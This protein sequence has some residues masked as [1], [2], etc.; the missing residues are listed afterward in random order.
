MITPTAIPFRFFLLGATGRTG[1]PFLVQALACGHF[2]TVFIRNVSESIN[3]HLQAVGT[4]SGPVL[5]T[6]CVCHGVRLP[7]FC[8]RMEFG[9]AQARKAVWKKGQLESHR[10]FSV[11]LAQRI[12]KRF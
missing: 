4:G 3:A 6:C 12:Q 8:S 1:L 7:S 9:E 11:K 2:V 5:L 10:D